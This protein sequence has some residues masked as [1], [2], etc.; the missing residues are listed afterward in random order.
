MILH[1]CSRDVDFT[2][3]VKVN[4]LVVSLSVCVP[5]QYSS[6]QFS[7]AIV[8]MAF[9]VLHIQ[10]NTLHFYDRIK[11]PLLLISV[12]FCV[13][14]CACVARPHAACVWCGRAGLRNVITRV[15]MHA[16]LSISGGLYIW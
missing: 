13:R 15:S 1:S 12:P 10:E 5:V 3:I 9:S 7:L 4:V 11:R 6:V 16:L 2:V 14:S 8:G